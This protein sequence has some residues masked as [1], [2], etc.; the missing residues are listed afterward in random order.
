MLFGKMKSLFCYESH[1][2]V[3]PK[4]HQLTYSLF[5]CETKADISGNGPNISGAASHIDPMISTV[6]SRGNST[7]SRH[8]VA[9]ISW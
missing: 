8:N 6:T 1:S 5:Y 2:L 3:L 4:I 7:R 9:Y